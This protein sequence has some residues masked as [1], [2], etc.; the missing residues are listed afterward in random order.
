MYMA[1]GGATIG[2]VGGGHTFT[3][4]ELVGIITSVEGGRVKTIDEF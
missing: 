3:Y 1:G 2:P 4:I